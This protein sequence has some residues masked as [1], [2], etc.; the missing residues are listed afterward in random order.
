MFAACNE[1]LDEGNLTGTRCRCQ[2]SV[3]SDQLSVI[4]YQ[5]SVHGKVSLGGRGFRRIE[6]GS[7]QL[8]EAGVLGAERNGYGGECW[9]AEAHPTEEEVEGGTGSAALG[10]GDCLRSEST[11][12]AFFQ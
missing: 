3:G 8:T 4:S 1:D 2:L 11:L 7:I 12:R 5:L 10:T 9:R 6:S